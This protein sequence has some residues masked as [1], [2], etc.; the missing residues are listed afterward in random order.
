ME[1]LV[2]ALID[3]L[4]IDQLLVEEFI[5][6]HQLRIDLY[7]QVEVVVVDR[8][9]IHFDGVKVQLIE[10]QRRVMRRVVLA[11][12]D[13]GLLNIEFWR[14]ANRAKFVPQRKSCVT[15]VSAVASETAHRMRTWATC[16][17]ESGRGENCRHCQ[18]G[19]Y[20]PV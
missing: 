4:L 17:S 2:V 9:L 20:G 15:A 16:L 10:R 19:A 7:F 14:V 11:V 3:E 5:V 13:R 8:Q 12:Q 6:F 18:H 1:L